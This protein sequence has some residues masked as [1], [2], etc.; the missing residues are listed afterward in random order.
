MSC[1]LNKGIR[2]GSDVLHL[3]RQ[4]GEDA[5]EKQQ[6]SRLGGKSADLAFRREKADVRDRILAMSRVRL[7][8]FASRQFR[9]LS[10]RKAGR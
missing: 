4:D 3:Q 9:R 2:G 5:R 7:R 10:Q 8:V 1:L 6:K